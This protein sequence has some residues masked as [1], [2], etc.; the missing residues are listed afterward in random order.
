MPHHWK[1]EE[2]ALKGL[3]SHWV[4]DDILV[5]ARPSTVLLRERDLIAQ[6]KRLALLCSPGMLSILICT[7]L[8]Y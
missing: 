7:H 1:E 5:M 2:K 3:F 6:F 4:T 8:S